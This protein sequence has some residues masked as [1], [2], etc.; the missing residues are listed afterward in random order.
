[1]VDPHLNLRLELLQR[2]GWR[3]DFRGPIRRAFEVSD[4]KSFGNARRENKGCIGRS[5]DVRVPFNAKAGFGAQHNAEF[6]F[7]VPSAQQ[8]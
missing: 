7:V 5:H 2:I 4:R 3:D 6:V 8:C 1:M